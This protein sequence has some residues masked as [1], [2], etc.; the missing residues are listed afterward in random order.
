M[1]LFSKKKKKKAKRTT[2]TSK[3][4]TKSAS[5]AT[6][7]P[8]QKGK[9]QEP[10]QWRNSKGVDEPLRIGRGI[11]TRDEYYAGQDGK[12]IHPEIDEREL[13]RRS[14]VLDIDDEQNLAVT[15]IHTFKSKDYPDIPNDANKRKYERR[16]QT[17]SG[18]NKELKPI[19]LEKDRFELAP[20]NEDVTEAQAKE[21]LDDIE[22]ASNQNKKR[23][24]AF[25][26]KKKAGS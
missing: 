20:A 16:I 5:K 21:M 23:M 10:N 9:T 25:R 7:K 6:S 2:P 26:E 1:G 8:K 13:Y 22:N 18:S 19:R 12:E 15:K 24:Q 11:R 17:A 3:V 14:V 4:A